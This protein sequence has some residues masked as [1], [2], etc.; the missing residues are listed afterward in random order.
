MSDSVRDAY[1][2]GVKPEEAATISQLHTIIMAARPEL[3]PRLSYGLL[4]YVLGKDLRHWICAIGTTKKAVGLRFLFGAWL[5]DPQGRLRP[6]SSHLSTLDLAPGEAPD[7]EFI[8][9]L[10]NETVERLPEL[11]ALASQT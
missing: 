6:G 7:A 1:V 3:T 11:K 5:R 9:S 8:S 10:V 2:A 4:M